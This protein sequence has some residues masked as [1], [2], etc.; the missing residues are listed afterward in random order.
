MYYTENY[1]LP[2]WEETDRIMRTDFNAAMAS[3]EGGLT[4]C[5]DAAAAGSVQ[6]SSALYAGLFRLAYNHWHAA[7]AL[8]SFPAQ[9][10]VFRQGFAEG[11]GGKA[12]NMIQMEDQMWMTNAEELMNMTHL[13][14]TISSSE[15]S[16]AKGKDNMDIY[17]TPPYGGR[18]NAFVLDISF[19]SSGGSN[20]GLCTIS[21]YKGKELV[22][23]VPGDMRLTGNGGTVSKMPVDFLLH[24]Q[25]R[26]RLHIQMTK[27]DFTATIKV[28]K[29]VDC[30]QVTGYQIPGTTINCPISAE[31]DGQGG[32]FLLH[33]DSYGEG[34]D[35]T[36]TW[37]GETLTPLTVRGIIDKQGRQIKEAEF[38]LARRIPASSSA[39]LAVQCHSGGDFS[40][41]DWGAVL[42]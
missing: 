10:G 15:I 25:Q 13:R 1:H 33:Y 7:A 23:S 8:E 16:S 35:I 3:L 6:A 39:R 42:L 32:L 18:L 5:R 26:Y 41:Y 14:P 36:L 12:P 28:N 19:N 38:R 21:L 22:G 17:F 9:A 30:L 37:D 40:L 34:A 29:A 31:E 20:T 11:E 27:L 24:P 2:Q 4:E